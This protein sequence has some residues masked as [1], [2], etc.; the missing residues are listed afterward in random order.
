MVSRCCNDLNR[1]VADTRWSPT[2]TAD[3]VRHTD[4]RTRKTHTQHTAHKACTQSTHKTMIHRGFLMGRLLTLWMSVLC[5]F[6]VWCGAKTNDPVLSRFNRRYG[7][8]ATAL[9]LQKKREMDTHNPS[10]CFPVQAR[11]GPYRQAFDSIPLSIKR[12]RHAH[13]EVS[14]GIAPPAKVAPFPSCPV[15]TACPAYMCLV[16]VVGRVS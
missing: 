8:G 14:L 10:G 3:T 15:V 11:P 5:L 13:V 1:A 2:N 9:L 4:K 16:G 6:C 12:G 7:E